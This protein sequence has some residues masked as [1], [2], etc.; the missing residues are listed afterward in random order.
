MAPLRIL[1]LTFFA[2]LGLL[3]QFYTMHVEAQ[4]G[5]VPGYQAA[6]DLAAW[7]MSCTRVFTSPYAH[8]LRHWG[9]VSRG[10][11]LDLSL[12][13]LA[14]PYFLL[15][16]SY[17]A[18]RRR[19][20]LAPAAFLAVAAAS[21]AFNVYLACILKFVLKE[22]CIICASTYVINGTCFTCIL[23]DYYK[24]RGITSRPKSA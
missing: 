20:P 2:S 9:L 21:I 14:L 23:V 13:Q 16:L 6:C 5:R 3:L 18:A 15:L 11:L 1:V 10:S 4:A 24:R 22:F 17:P 8:I 19:S 7:G 12:P